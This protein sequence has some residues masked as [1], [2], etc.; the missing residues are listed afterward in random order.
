MPKYKFI[1]LSGYMQLKY[2]YNE[3]F[4]LTVK[5]RVK[6]LNFVTADNLRQV[7]F[8]RELAYLQKEINI[9][10]LFP[11]GAFRNPPYAVFFL[12]KKVANYYFQKKVN[13]VDWFW[14]Y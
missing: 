8:K 12:K 13:K 5:Y 1:V 7:I 11:L 14:Y 2:R 10:R 4:Y 9:C 3:D 6:V